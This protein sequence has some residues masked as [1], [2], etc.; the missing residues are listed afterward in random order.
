MTDRSATTTRPNGPVERRPK[1]RHLISS[2]A[3][4]VRCGAR[5]HAGQI[6]P[7]ASRWYYR[8]PT[9]CRVLVYS[10]L[11][12]LHFIGHS[13][14]SCSTAFINSRTLRTVRHSTKIILLSTKYSANDGPRQ[15]T[16][17]SRSITDG[18]YL[19]RASCFDTRQKNYFV[20]CPVS[21]TRQSMLYRVLFLDTRQSIFLFFSQPNFY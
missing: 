16:V 13:T 11:Y 7:W 4:L 10:I 14:K 20:E 1:E 2:P 18:H 3:G 21:S 8:N 19:C 12:W 15:R 6:D 5:A 9:L 17:S